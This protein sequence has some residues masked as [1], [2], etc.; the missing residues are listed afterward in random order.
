MKRAR[1][2]GLAKT[3][4]LGRHRNV[5]QKLVFVD[6]AHRHRLPAKS[7]TLHDGA[8]VLGVFRVQF[9]GNRLGAL[10]IG[11]GIEGGIARRLDE[12]RALRAV[13]RARSAPH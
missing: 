11:K 7:E 6:E 13:A 10:F 4:V 12:K 2:H 5:G 3:Q 1:S 8:L 9:V